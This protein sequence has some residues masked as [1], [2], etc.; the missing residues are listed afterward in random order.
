MEPE[1]EVE[2]K[3]LLNEAAAQIRAEAAEK[4]ARRPKNIGA[5]A[6]GLVG[7]SLGGVA[8]GAAAIVVGPIAGYRE[9]GTSGILK[10]AVGG[11]A[12]GVASTALGI[13]SGIAKL[14]DGASA[15]ASDKPLPQLEALS[16][17]ENAE[18]DQR[19]YER[20]RNALYEGLLAEDNEDEIKL[21]APT[22]T[23]LYE[24]LAIEPTATPN[25]IRRAYFKLAQRY[26]P[27]KNLNDPTATSKFQ[28]ISDAY[29][30][31]S[32]PIKREQY[33][34]MGNAESESLL[35]PKSLFV[36]MFGNDK[37]GHLV[38]DLATSTLLASEKHQEEMSPESTN[39]RVAERRKQFQVNRQQKLAAL[40]RKRLQVYVDGDK[41]KFIEHAKHEATLLRQEPFGRDM[42]HTIGYCY[43]KKAQLMLGKG[44]GPLGLRGFFSELSDK[45]H[46]FR[47]KADALEGTMRAVQNSSCIDDEESPEDAVRRETV[48]VL[49]AVWLASVV[50]IQT[51]LRKVVKDILSHDGIAKEILRERAQ[52]LIEL[53]KIFQ[54]A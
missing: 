54:Q 31:L 21:A 18:E 8:I 45:A 27:D 20:E 15:H 42:L 40:L 9:S 53:G 2:Q 33:H 14:V 52:G 44:K 35:D 23:K 12:V 34:R 10:G 4:D 48:S 19:S 22:D 29:Q 30:V 38:G 36:L 51:T 13:G 50:D 46:M 47:S 1:A 37:F 3:K 28:Q 26:H 39:K 5:G 32:D 25:E 7:D 6:I 11:L 41:E 16:I 17:A 49:G 24:E 43:R